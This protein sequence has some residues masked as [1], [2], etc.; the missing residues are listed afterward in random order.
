VSHRDK[1]QTSL[2][3][4]LEPKR[5]LDPERRRYVEH[6]LDLY[7]R[8]PATTGHVHRNDRRLA[9]SLF[10]QS[11]TLTIVRGALAM[12]ALRRARRSHHNTPLA[13]IRSLAYFLPVIDELHSHQ[14][15]DGA[16]L[17]FLD[18]Q[19]RMLTGS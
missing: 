17:E 5:L 13:K 19:L 12:A 18:D 8:N 14:D 2:F 4:E 11:V 6:V 16:Y 10:D 9:N 1:R 7:R 15:L 3:S